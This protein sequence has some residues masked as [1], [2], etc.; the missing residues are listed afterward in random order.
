[1]TDNSASRGRLRGGGVTWQ[2]PSINCLVTRGIFSTHDAYSVIGMH[3]HQKYSG[4]VS[5]AVEHSS[6]FMNC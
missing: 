5:Q 4:G 6:Q 3:F 1:M 2:L